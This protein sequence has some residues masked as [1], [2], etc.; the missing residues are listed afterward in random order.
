MWCGVFVQVCECL[1]LCVREWA[2]VFFHVFL[3]VFLCVCA[4]II[5]INMHVYIHKCILEY[6]YLNMYVRI[7]QTTH[8]RDSKSQCIIIMQV[9]SRINALSNS[10][11]I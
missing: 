9:M 6:T 2:C 7:K 11:H 10:T 5:D 8:R 1:C 4:C 3:G